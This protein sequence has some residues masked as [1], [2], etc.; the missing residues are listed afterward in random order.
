MD[1]HS[2]VCYLL[3]GSPKINLSR[4]SCWRINDVSLPPRWGW[5]SSSRVRVT[6]ITYH[7]PS[8]FNKISLQLGWLGLRPG[9]LPR[10]EAMD[11]KGCWKPSRSYLSSRQEGNATAICLFVVTWEWIKIN[12][13]PWT[14]RGA[15]QHFL[16]VSND[17]CETS[18]QWSLEGRGKEGHCS[19]WR[20]TRP[21]A[22]CLHRLWNVPSMNFVA[23]VRNGEK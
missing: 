6:S 2:F 9:K 23:Q 5:L 18:W 14:N 16:R 4:R 11:T 22:S 15:Y 20:F 17:Y 13:G 10:C 8:W 12:L 19:K 3:N 21:G 1:H 7:K